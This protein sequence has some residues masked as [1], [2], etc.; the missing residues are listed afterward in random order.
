MGDTKDRATDVAASAAEVAANAAEEA[1]N[2]AAA[3]G[4]AKRKRIN[5]VVIGVLVVLV[6]AGFAGSMAFGQST[7][8]KNAVVRDSNGQEYVLPLD[9]DTTLDVRTDKGWNQ[10]VVENGTVRVADADCPNRDCVKQGAIS[11]AGQQIV[12]LPHQLI[13]SI[14]A[15]G[16]KPDFDVVGQ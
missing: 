5:F 16:E 9:Q 15:E 12:C 11:K 8:A 2:V 6:L 14:S 1:A 3:S 7:P 13:V 4:L 10:I